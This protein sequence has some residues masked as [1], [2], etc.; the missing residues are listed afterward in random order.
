MDKAKF[1]MLIDQSRVNGSGDAEAQIDELL[2]L[3]SALD[4]DDIAE[5]DHIFSTYHEQAYTWPLWGAAYVIGGGCSDDSFMDFR[6]W[7]ISR[8]EAVYERALKEP[9]W[10][11]D[12]VTDEDGD[13]RVEGFQYVPSQAWTEKTG[14]SDDEFPL[15][16]IPGASRD[17][18]GEEWTEDDLEVRFPKLY[19]RFG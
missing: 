11:A 4:A 15:R 6:G 12:F 8:G 17:P 10:L 1:W 7:L 16:Q 13:C 18:R 9:D 5:F 3:V 19:K 14:K 2:K